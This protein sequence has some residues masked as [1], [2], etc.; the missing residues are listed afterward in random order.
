[1]STLPSIETLS[2]VTEALLGPPFEWCQVTGGNVTLEDAS[3]SGGT[4]GGVYQIAEFAISK[5]PITNARYQKFLNDPL[6]YIDS[7]WW[8]FSAEA[9]QWRKDH[10]RPRP[11]AFGG[12]DLPR[13]RV[14]WFESVAFCSWLSA[15]LKTVF[16]EGCVRLPTEHEWQRAAIGDTSWPYPWGEHLS[17]TF[18]NYGGQIGHPTRVGH[19]RDSKSPYGV[20]D[21]VGNVWEWCLTAWGADDKDV[22]G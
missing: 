4:P 15:K 20:L 14:S 10:R 7:Q 6:G 17:E 2:R 1:M 19:Y 9:T 11:T 21:M 12:A 8:E 13:T 16:V 22:G 3:R 18:G 5:Y